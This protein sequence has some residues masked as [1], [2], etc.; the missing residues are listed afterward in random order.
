MQNNNNILSPIEVVEYSKSELND[1]SF[2]PTVKYRDKIADICS[3]LPK[4]Q[5]IKYFYLVLKTE[6]SKSL[7]LGNTPDWSLTYHKY[8]LARLD[9]GANPNEDSDYIIS[10]H[11]KK[12]F[13][14]NHFYQWFESYGIY[15]TYSI[16]RQSEDVKII[17]IAHN[18]KHIIHPETYYETTSHLF[19]DFT[20][21]FIDKML[22]IIKA[23]CPA[24]ALTTFIKDA[25]YRKDI[26]KR[27]IVFAHPTLSPR[28][29]E[30]LHHAFHGFTSK[31]MAKILSLDNRTIEKYAANAKKKLGARN[32]AHAVKKALDL[33]IIT[34]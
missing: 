9:V 29:K 25:D 13:L 15:E 10:D 12:D 24:M 22:D 23:C 20:L 1:Y 30:I 32:I 18:D 16:L 17:A 26:I 28:E 14:T 21:L 3:D 19:E 7:C 5:D 33:R 6:F 2:L 11:V 34:Y 31:E 27:K 8:N 4:I